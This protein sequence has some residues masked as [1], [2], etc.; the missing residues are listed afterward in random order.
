MRSS[1]SCAI[2]APTA[3]FLTKRSILYD[4]MGRI[5]NEQ[6]FTKASQA[7]GAVYAPSYTY[8]LAGN[9]RSSTN[10]V[11]P[12]SA[13]PAAPSIALTYTLDNAGHLQTLGSSLQSA[14]I[15]Q[16]T[17]SLPATLFSPPTVQSSPCLN[18]VTTQYTAFGGLANALYG[19]GLTLNR[20]YDS[21]LRTTCESDK[22]SF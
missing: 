20:A 4:A 17:Y 15:N 18:S 22:G 21:R 1:A 13:T 3:G 7:S 11:G 6:Q 19:T 12:T 8:D 5:V 16:T 10:G 9:L 2:T 14:T